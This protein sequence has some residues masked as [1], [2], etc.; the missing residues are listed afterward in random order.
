ML[1]RESEKVMET[2]REHGGSH[3]PCPKRKNRAMVAVEVCQARCTF[4]RK[5]PI[6]QA[7]RNPPLR[8]F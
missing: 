3:L 6:Y 8:L 1:R 4:C 5:C 7:W 2:I